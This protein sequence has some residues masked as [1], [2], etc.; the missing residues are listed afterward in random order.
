MNKTKALASTTFDW[1]KNILMKSLER[2]DELLAFWKTKRNEVFTFRKEVIEDNWDGFEVARYNEI[3]GVHD[4]LPASR[5]LIARLLD[6]YESNPYP[7]KQ[8][9]VL[10]F[11]EKAIP[12][13]VFRWSIKGKR[14][15]G[16]TAWVILFEEPRLFPP[17]FGQFRVRFPVKVEIIDIAEVERKL[18]ESLRPDRTL[19]AADVPALLKMAPTGKSYA[20]VREKLKERQW[21]WG[22]R[23]ESGKMAKV[24]IAPRA[25]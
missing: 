22:M 24:V 10:D 23:R 16:R 5:M 12:E 17:K 1:P 4:N 18:L 15:T 25:G 2:L 7:G 3:I 13:A 9:T 6:S 11:A 21:V 19:L 8:M 14:C 20:T